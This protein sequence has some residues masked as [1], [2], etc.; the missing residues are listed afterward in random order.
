MFEYKHIN[1]SIY[2]TSL[3]HEASMFNFDNIC[4][5]ALSEEMNINHLIHKVLTDECS[6]EHLC[7]DLRRLSPLL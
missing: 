4:N 2:W 6:N 5:I 3:V 1:A 7:I